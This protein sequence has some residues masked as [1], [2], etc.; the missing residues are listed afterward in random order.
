MAKKSWQQIK[1]GIKRQAQEF[2]LDKVMNKRA[3]VQGSGMVGFREIS[4][5]ANEGG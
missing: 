5:G 4:P 2:V 3:Q 1:K